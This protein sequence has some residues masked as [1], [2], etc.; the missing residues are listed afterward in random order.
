MRGTYHGNSGTEGEQDPPT[1]RDAQQRRI[2]G[3]VVASLKHF[4][5]ANRS[6]MHDWTMRGDYSHERILDIDLVQ[7]SVQTV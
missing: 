7:C 6:A 2:I 5:G 3:D 4:F 1:R